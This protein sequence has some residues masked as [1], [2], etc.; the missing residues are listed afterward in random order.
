MYSGKRA[1]FDAVEKLVFVRSKVPVFC[2]VVWEYSGKRAVFDA[3]EKLAFA[4]PKVPV[5]C[6][7]MWGV[8]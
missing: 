5:F 6:I 8:F 7:G 1:V 4:R 3:V 2:I